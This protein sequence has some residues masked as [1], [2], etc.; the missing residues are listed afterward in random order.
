MNEV[1]K[2]PYFMIDKQ[3]LDN[4]F[5]KLKDALAN[6]WPN[7]ISGEIKFQQYEKTIKE[8]K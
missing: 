5:Y 2:T 7:Y 8:R 3:A 1:L 6:A 4:E